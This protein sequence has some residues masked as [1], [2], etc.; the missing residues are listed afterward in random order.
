MLSRLLPRAMAAMGQA[1][2]HSLHG[3][4]FACGDP[5]LWCSSAVFG[6]CGTCELGEY[7]KL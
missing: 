4:G 6:N 3:S 7:I 1:D 2:P 5:I